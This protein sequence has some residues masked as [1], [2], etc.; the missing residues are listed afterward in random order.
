MD[1][2]ILRGLLM[3]AAIGMTALAVFFLRGRR[4]SWPAY[5]FWGL[6]AVLIPVLGPFVVILARPGRKI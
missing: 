4:L 1:V 3:A 6:L 2:T 5:L